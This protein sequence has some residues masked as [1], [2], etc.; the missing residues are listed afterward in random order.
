[1]AN[2][3][4]FQKIKR[5]LD[6]RNFTCKIFYD[7]Y[8]NKVDLGTNEVYLKENVDYLLQDFKKIFGEQDDE[9]KR[10]KIKIQ[11]LELENYKLQ[12]RIKSYEKRQKND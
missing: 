5:K 7:F 11:D 10:L 6:G 9:I 3:T 2:H 4:Q 1:M 12:R 8:M